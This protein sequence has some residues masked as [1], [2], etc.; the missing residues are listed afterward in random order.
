MQFVACL[1]MS[2]PPDHNSQEQG[3]H[4]NDDNSNSNS[5]SGSPFFTPL[6]RGEIGSAQ[7]RQGLMSGGQDNPSSSINSTA[8]GRG[9]GGGGDG[10]VLS[11]SPGGA[12]KTVQFWT[13]WSL[14]LLNAFNIT[15]VSTLYK[16]FGGTF[17]HD[18]HFLSWVRPPTPLHCTALHGMALGTAL[19]CTA[20]HGMALGT[21]LH[22]TIG[23]SF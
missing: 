20:L 18:D 22:C 2:N 7:E 16:T 23:K 17:I 5:S 13:V 9:G 15:F 6:P 11:L 8:A 14:F 10:G 19:H 12:V 4:Y 1:F 3:Q 21:A